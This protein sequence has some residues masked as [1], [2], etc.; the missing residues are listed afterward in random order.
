M[1]GIGT[2][3]SRLKCA[4]ELV[5]EEHLIILQTTGCQT[6]LV[7]MMHLMSSELCAKSFLKASFILLN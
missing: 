2:P 6:M 4:T 7:A 5:V 1:P 3:D